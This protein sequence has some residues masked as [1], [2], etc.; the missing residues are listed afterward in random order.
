MRQVDRMNT[1]IQNLVMISRSQENEEKADMIDSDLTKAVKETAD[2]FMPVAAQDEKEIEKIIPEG[3]RMKA[4]ES[5]IRQL[6]SLLLDNAIK[7]C[8]QKGKI[9]IEQINKAFYNK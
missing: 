8:D 5:Q 7:Y 2:T 9:T 1:L 4:D 3:I 6:A